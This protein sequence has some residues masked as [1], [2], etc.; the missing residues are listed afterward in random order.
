MKRDFYYKAFH[1]FSVQVSGAVNA[2][3][4]STLRRV[5]LPVLLLFVFVL[6]GTGHTRAQLSP[7]D[8]A[9]VQFNSDNPDNFAFVALTDIPPGEQIKFTDNGWKSDNTWRATEGVIEWTAPNEGVDCG[10]VV[11]IAGTVASTG[12]VVQITNNPISFS[13]SGDQIIAYQGNDSM[14]A[15]LNDE[16]AGI[17]QADAADSNTSAL[18]QG[19]TDGLDAVALDEKDNYIYDGSLTTGTKAELL[20]AI[21]DNNNWT[22]NNSSQQTFSGTF[23]VTDCSEPAITVSPVALS[24]FMYMEGQGPSDEQTFEVSGTHLTDDISISPASGWEISL[25]GGAGFTPADP[26]VLTQSGGTVS[27]TTIYVRLAAGLDIGLQTGE[28]S[29]SSTGADTQTVSLSGQVL[30]PYQEC[31]VQSEVFLYE[32]FEDAAVLYT[33]P[34][35]EWTDG[36]NDYFTRVDGTNIS[37]GVS[38]SN[39][40]G[41]GWF[42]AQDTDADGHEN[43]GTVMTFTGISLP[44][45]LRALYFSIFLAEDDSDDGNED[46]DADTAL[47][48]KYRFDGAAQWSDLLW[49]EALPGGYNKEPA[50]DMDF[51]GVGDA[52]NEI[53]DTFT[54]FQRSIPLPGNEN[55]V[56]IR[57]EFINMDGGDEDIGID[58]IKLSGD[59]VATT[60]WDG[61]SWDNGNPDSTKKAVIQADYNTDDD[62]GSIEACACKIAQGAT[63]TV[64]PQH[65]LQL[66][67]DLEIQGDLVVEHEG[68]FVQKN[69]LAV[70]NIAGTVIIH[71]TTTGYTEYDY[72]YWGTPVS[73]TTVEDV[74]N[75]YSTLSQGSTTN[76]DDFSPPDRIYVHDTSKFDD[77]DSDTFDDEQDNWVVTTGN[78]IPGTGYIVMGAGSDI[79]FDPD[80]ISTGLK[81]SVQF[82]GTPNNGIISVPVVLDE[83]NTDTGGSNNFNNNKNFIANPYASAIDIEKFYNRNSSLLDGTFYFWTHYTPISSG[84]PGP[85]AY[86]FTNDDY[87]VYSIGSGGVA[88]ASGGSA[89]SRYVASCQGFV[90][91]V[92]AAGTLE[93]N[94]SMRV[95]SDNT[96]FLH[97]R[98]PLDRFWLNMKGQDGTFRQIL[99]GF[100]EGATDGYDPLYDAPRVENGNNNDLFSIIEGDPR[101][102]A[103]QGLAPFRPDKYV[104]LGLEIVDPGSYSIELDHSE[105]IFAGGQNI[106]LYD[107]YENVIHNLSHNPYFFYAGLGT[108]I[109]DRFMVLFDPDTFVSTH[110]I[111]VRKDG[112]S[113]HQDKDILKVEAV[114][115]D[116][117]RV[118][119]YNITGQRIAGYTYHSPSVQVPLQ[120]VRSHEIVILKVTTDDG[121]V[122]AGKILIR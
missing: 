103:I 52:G 23:T 73:N 62:G 117:S 75:T 109:S 37:A 96:H 106:Y 38:L 22:G 72:T 101:P 40:Q 108:W 42:G 105:G 28:V 95:K 119:L 112:I 11:T 68:S 110:G 45:G 6:S 74:F 99:I 91:T 61:T 5:S 66:E 7:G 56:D 114:A 12:S 85:Y 70:S 83:Y 13:S 36:S 35:G 30:T 67:S 81:Q 34:D 4:F 10:T 46:W 39:L 122:Y 100:F 41:S 24:G 19:L 69:D 116:I 82:R 107:Q 26:I 15:A 9:F 120:S 64:T 16:G 44:E 111:T 8:I 63:F 97:T 50:I 57:I 43:D 115:A 58:D 14:I 55:S 80:D 92:T 104:V 89:P 90:A 84:T 51:D 31:D 102:F 32:D 94:N 53:T 93:F 121:K 25:S 21:N 71:K 17:W 33:V 29:C 118:D 86:N 88:S 48:I 113:Y 49:V 47:H 65:Y 79:P 2:F 20:N 60:V 76:S 98:V 78:M 54:Q 87:S 3:A 18:P 27:N 59:T 77:Y 1:R